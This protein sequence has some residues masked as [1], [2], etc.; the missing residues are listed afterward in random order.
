MVDIH[1]ALSSWG[2]ARGLTVQRLLK[3]RL[4]AAAS[5]GAQRTLVRRRAFFSAD[6]SRNSKALGEC[7]VEHQPARC[8]STPGPWTANPLSGVRGKDSLS[9]LNPVPGAGS[10]SL[11]RA[12]GAPIRLRLFPQLTERQAWTI[13]YVQEV[14]R[15]SLVVPSMGGV[16]AAAKEPGDPNR[17]TQAL[18]EEYA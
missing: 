18:I 17:I 1:G 7:L 8:A 11:W 6:L 12:A 15:L 9:V 4:A 13:F 2:L 5:F 10:C 3:V 14:Y 16:S